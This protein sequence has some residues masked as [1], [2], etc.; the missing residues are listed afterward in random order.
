V[1]RAKVD[2]TIRFV[3]QP[4]LPLVRSGM[5]ALTERDE[6]IEPFLT[7]ALVGEVVDL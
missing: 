6:I 2:L 1:I 5:T 3:P 4:T 7:Q